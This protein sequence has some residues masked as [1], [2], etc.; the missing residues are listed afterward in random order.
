LNPFIGA[1]ALV[2]FFYFLKITDRPFI[3]L[4][5]LGFLLALIPA[6]LSNSMEIYRLNHAFPFFL[7]SAVLGIQGL[8]NTLPLRISTPW[9]LL[10]FL[11]TPFFIDTYK[12]FGHF[13]GVETSPSP[14]K[15]EFRS[16]KFFEI[17]KILERRNAETGPLHIFS[18]F[19]LDYNNKFINAATWSF[20]A[21]QNPTLAHTPTRWTAVL[22]PSDMGP[23]LQK[24]F[25]DLEYVPLPP[26]EPLP[27]ALFLIP[28]REIPADVLQSWTRA[29]QI[30]RKVNFNVRM[31]D[32]ALPWDQFVGQLSPLE[33]KNLNDP[34]LAGIY[35]EKVG[36]FKGI[37]GDFQGATSAYQMALQYG[38]PTAHLYYSLGVAMKLLGKSSEAQK[39][40]QKSSE[41]SASQVIRAEEPNFSGTK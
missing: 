28:T 33:G 30:Y 17:F 11:I 34:F 9:F 21:T 15:L 41:A 8:K 19:S 37:S 5:S 35:W 16:V 27:L 24:R 1:L 39:A 18:E 25:H 32:P 23:F 40:F 2:G 36:F 4:T 14:T 26:N 13:C 29:D 20:N 22:V 7:A 6:T 10:F 12:Y 3:L 38:Y 31:K